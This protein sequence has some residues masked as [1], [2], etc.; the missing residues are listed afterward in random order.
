MYVAKSEQVICFDCDDT[1]IMWDENH[2]QPFNGAVEVICP[3]DSGV[4]YHRPHHR[5]IRFLK[6]Q[7]A[8]GMTVVVW[9]AA[10]TKWAEAVVKALN[11]ENHV[12]IVMSKPV[13]WVDDLEKAEDVLGVRLYLSEDGY[14]S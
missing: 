11:I 5:H 10:G 4:S 8:K 2:T 12:D 13:K 7:Y 3:W 14:S 1:L 9:S 6:K